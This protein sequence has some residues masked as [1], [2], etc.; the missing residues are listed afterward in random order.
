MEEKHKSDTFYISIL[1]VIV[2]GFLDAY[3]YLCRGRVFAN[4]QTGNIVLLGVKLIDGDIK[5]AIYYIWPILAFIV[6]IFVAEII[7]D[8]FLEHHALHWKQI[9]LAFEVI[10][11]FLAAFIPQQYNMLCNISISFVCALQ[12]QSFKKF[13]DNPYASTMCTGNLRTGTELLYKYFQT[14][15]KKTLNK[16]LQY[17]IIILFFILGA[18]FGAVSTLYLSNY[19]IILTSILLMIVII[20]MKLNKDV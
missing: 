8:H 11:L 5:A 2:G 7:K 4:A 20:T 19:A 18:C 17:Y 16:S 12:F 14:K 9:V 13:K 3:S 15:E 10:I 1:L 6:G